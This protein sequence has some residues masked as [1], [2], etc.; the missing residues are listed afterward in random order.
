MRRPI[1]SHDPDPAEDIIFGRATYVESQG[2]C[3]IK[4]CHSDG[5]KQVISPMKVKRFGQIKLWC[6][7]SKCSE[8]AGPDDFVGDLARSEKIRVEE[9]YRRKLVAEKERRNSSLF[10]HKEVPRVSVGPLQ[11]PRKRMIL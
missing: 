5:K 3:F 2:I 6:H 1:N 7:P 4:G 8:N 9:I 11:P 10:G